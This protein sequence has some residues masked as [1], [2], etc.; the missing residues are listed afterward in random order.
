MNTIEKMEREA[1]S[2]RGRRIKCA[3][4]L[5]I[6]FVFQKFYICLSKNFEGILIDQLRKYLEPHMSSKMSGFRKGFSCQTVL[7]D[8]IETCKKYLDD[9]LYTGAV[10]TDLSKAF[11]CLPHCLVISKLAAYGVDADSCKL[12]VSYFSER[13]QK[14][15]VGDNASDWLRCATRIF[16]GTVYL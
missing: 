15:K 12:F 9:K 5:N 4:Y 14:V 2:Y 1:M 10:L 7:M 3:P 13:L 16:N 11:D 6:T 8:F